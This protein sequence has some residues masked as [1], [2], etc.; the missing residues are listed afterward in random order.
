MEVGLTPPVG[1][2]TPRQCWVGRQK[3][4]TSLPARC[5]ERDQVSIGGHRIFRRSEGRTLGKSPSC[6]NGPDTSLEVNPGLSPPREQGKVIMLGHPRNTR[7]VQL[8]ALRSVGHL[9]PAHPNLLESWA[10]GALM[11][12][13]IINLWLASFSFCLIMVST[14]GPAG[15]FINWF[16]FPS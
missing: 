9:Q 10:P 4:D 3:P 11:K 16:C 7:G 2:P 12:M 6:G 5:R 1:F 8:P 15:S 14:Q 13:K